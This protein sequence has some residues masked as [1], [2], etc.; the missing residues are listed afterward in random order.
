MLGQSAPLQDRVETFQLGKA[1][2]R[3]KI[4]HACLIRS[5]C[6]DHDRG[7]LVR[8]MRPVPPQR[9]GDVDVISHHHAALAARQRGGLGKIEDRGV[10]ERADRCALIF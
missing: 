9:H 5:G 8:P 4:A 6:A 2:H 3:R 1:K 10:P 7:A